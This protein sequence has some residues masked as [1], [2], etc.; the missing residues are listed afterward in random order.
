MVSL[1]QIPLDQACK[2][3]GDYLHAKGDNE[4]GEA[5]SVFGILGKASEA[6]RGVVVK[7]R[8]TGIRDASANN[9]K[10][11]KQNNGDLGTNALAHQK[12]DGHNGEHRKTD[13][14]DGEGGARL[15]RSLHHTAGLNEGVVVSSRM[16]TTT[17]LAA[18]QR[19]AIPVIALATSVHGGKSLIPITALLELV[20]GRA[21]GHK[22][23]A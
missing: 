3:E 17:F 16:R 18:P 9:V 23:Q 20:V 14:Y 15:E 22:E 11:R 13:R 12:E 8:D 2:N 4:E 7:T 1:L 5:R 19:V 10:Q 21:N 6:A